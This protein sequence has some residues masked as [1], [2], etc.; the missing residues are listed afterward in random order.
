MLIAGAK[1]HA[2]EVLEIIYGDSTKDPVFFD[3]ISKDLP[4]TIFNRFRIISS[5]QEA[6]KYFQSFPEFVLG[7]GNP[8]V[9]KILFE[10]L[11]SCGGKM[12]SV[13]AKDAS[14]SLFNVVLEDGV[15]IMNGVF[16]SNDVHIGKGSL[17]NARAM[18]HHD[19]SIGSFCEIG[20]GAILTGRCSLGENSFLG[21]GVIVNPNVTIGKNVIVGAGAV[22]INNLTDNVTAVGVPAKIVSK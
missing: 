6:E 16:I 2:G 15:N 14:I 18:L 11:S 20:P 17:I 12:V 9:R 4:A 7:T 10:K 1:G 19:C 8:A 5:V 21:A 22:V 3:D 13:I